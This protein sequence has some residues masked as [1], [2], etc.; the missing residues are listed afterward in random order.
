MSA[1][2]ANDKKL[3]IANATELFTGIA[4]APIEHVRIL[5]YNI[6]PYDGYIEFLET[7]KRRIPM[8]SILK[9]R[10]GANSETNIEQI[11][12]PSFVCSLAYRRL[13][14]ILRDACTNESNE[15]QVNANL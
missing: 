8:E 6:T 9:L 10:P 12:T 14:R 3:I 11:L 1:Q 2:K 15:S 5:P 7:V 4:Q 13:N